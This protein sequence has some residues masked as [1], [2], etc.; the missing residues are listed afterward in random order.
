MT[1][2]AV[3]GS[4]PSMSQHVADSVKGKCRVVAVSDSYRLAP[5]ADA[6]VSQDRSWWDVHR[7][8]LNFAGRKFCGWER[9][10]TELLKF[11]VRLGTGLN[12][13]LQGMRVAAMLGAT[14]ILLLGFDMHGSHF[15]GPHPKALANT[16]AE[17]F[18]EHI[19]Q[20][21]KWYGP[22]VVNC[23]PGSALTHFRMSTLEA[24]LVEKRSVA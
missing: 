21:S 5:W 15:F 24:E 7:E 11:D 4:G 9:S 23:T 8:A 1:L 20:F 16:T 13:G 2:F 19:R 12:S 17:R 14:K 6:L 10:G 22:E 18:R 3:L